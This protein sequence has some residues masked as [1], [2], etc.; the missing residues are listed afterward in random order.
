[1]TNPRFEALLETMRRLHDTKNHD[2]A[3][4][5]NPFSNFEDAAATAGCSVDT[6]F[7]VLVG[8]KLARL[9]EL[10]AAGKTPQHEPI[11]DTRI[12][13]AMYTAL[14]AS[15]HLRLSYDDRQLASA[16]SH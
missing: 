7:G 14:W 10:T 4:D 9:R 6:V 2:Y 5:T 11:D 15:Y 1:M 16:S 12:D 13:L 8:V 3:N